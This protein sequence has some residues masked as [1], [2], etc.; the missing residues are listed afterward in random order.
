MRCYLDQSNWKTDERPFR[1]AWMLGIERPYDRCAGARAYVCMCLCV[2]VWYED[3]ITI[4]L[5]H[6][7]NVFAYSHLWVSLS[8]IYSLARL[9]TRCTALRCHNM[10]RLVSFV[11]VL[12][13]RAVERVAVVRVHEI[14][15]SFY[16]QRKL[17]ST[18]RKLFHSNM[19][20]AIVVSRRNSFWFFAVE[21]EQSKHNV[22]TCA[23]N[24]AKRSTK[25]G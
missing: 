17:F 12:N 23:P 11:F 9:F 2:C 7:S 3:T 21:N 13:I 6:K 19:R 22:L 16:I 14:R 5:M 4:P 1:W 18:F 15:A 24:N 20:L 25:I 10:R 8:A